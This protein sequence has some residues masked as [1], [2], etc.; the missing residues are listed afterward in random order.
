M[1]NEAIF[2][3]ATVFCLGCALTAFRLGRQWATAYV[4]VASAV[5]ACVGAKISMI[6]GL[7]ITLGEAVYASIYLTSDM[8][9][10]RFGKKEGYK[11]I[12]IGFASLFVFTVLTQLALLLQ[13][14]DYAGEVS[15]AMGT[16]FEMSLRMTLG[17]ALAYFV[18]QHFDVWFYHFI[19]EKTKERF[20]WLRNNLSTMVSQ[21]LDSTIFYLVAFYGVF[22][23]LFQIA[24]AGYTVKVA[25][26]LCDTPFMYLSKRIKS[27]QGW[28]S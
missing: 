21:A 26:A 16:V 17:G 5:L 7:P 23:D 20:L 25:V 14:E 22:P 1:S 4:V 2:I 28:S 10:E 13:P 9:T 3:I 8:V 11:I 27:E 6:F 18:S 15:N 12:R 19:H 24:L